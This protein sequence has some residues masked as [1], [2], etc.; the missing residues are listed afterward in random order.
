MGPGD[1]AELV[2][3][4][5]AVDG[6]GLGQGLVNAA[7]HAQVDNGVPAD[8]LPQGGEDDHG[9]VAPFLGEEVDVLLNDAHLHQQDVDGAAGGVEQVVE[10][11]VGD[12]P[13]H[14]V[15]Q[16]GQGLGELHDPGVL[17]LV[18]QHGQHHRR[19]GQEDQLQ[20]GDVDGVEQDAPAGLRGEK[21]DEVL[22]AVVGGPGAG[23]NALEDVV[24][25]EGNGHAVHGEVGNHNDHNQRRQH[26]GLQGQLGFPVVPRHHGVG[27]A[28]LANGHRAF[29]LIPA[30]PEDAPG[31]NQWRSRWRSSGWPRWP[32]PGPPGR[33]PC[34][35]PP[36]C[37]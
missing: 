36:T 18:E 31:Q 35:D 9:T 28:G 11:T 15:G 32:C 21:V 25:L 20:E 12:G 16:V 5:A 26:H 23:G 10:D 3:A 13:A 29:L 8:V 24:I 22:K 37:G 27:L 14:K 6:Q 1:V 2:P 17:Q 33:R 7:D 34:R 19:P 30:G 4:V